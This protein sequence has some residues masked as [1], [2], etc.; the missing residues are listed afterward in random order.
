[1]KYLT[2][3]RHAKSSWDKPGVNDFDRPL[4]KRGREAAALMGAYIRNNNIT[5]EHVLCSSAARTRQTLSLMLPC[6]DNDPVITFRDRLYL[7]SPSQM[8]AQITSVPDQVSH[9]LVIGH[10][11][12]TQML[13]L[14]LVDPAQS[15]AQMT[16]RLAEKFPTAALAHFQFD[17]AAWKSI[18]SGSGA[19]K[20]FVTPRSL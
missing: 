5:P 18:V 4:N 12:G 6:L 8:L 13:A 14:D 2:L 3:L 7:A 19:L 20:A 17:T 11:P 15:N 1:M 16:E 9:L 10:N